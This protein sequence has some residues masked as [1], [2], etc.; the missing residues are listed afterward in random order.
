MILYFS[1][2]NSTA[3]SDLIKKKK[4]STMIH[5]TGFEMNCTFS[6]Q[7]SSFCWLFLYNK[8]CSQVTRHQDQDI[9]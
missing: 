3:I 8:L 5:P 2:K 6:L 1:F 9:A 7:G 4:I